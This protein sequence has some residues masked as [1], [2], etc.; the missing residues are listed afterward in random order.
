MTGWLGDKESNVAEINNIEILLSEK[1][2]ESVVFVKEEFLHKT[3]Q[4]K[5]VSGY[6]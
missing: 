6:F 4:K 2:Q 3:I 1:E 5:D